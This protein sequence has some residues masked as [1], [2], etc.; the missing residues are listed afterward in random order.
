MKKFMDED[1]LLTSDAAKKLYH[2]YAENMPIV[3][4]HCHINPQEICEDRKFE[5]ITQVW[6]GGDHY[7]WR[8][9][10]SNGVDEK[11]ITGDATDR[12][13][14]QKWAETLEKLIGNPL[15]HWS[16]LE[17]KRYF[18]Y[19]GYLNGET[20]EEVWNLCN[21]KLAQDDMTVRNIIKKSNVK[22]ICTT[23]DP[24]DTLEYHEKLAKD[25]TFDV[26]VLP[27]W[28]PDKAMNLEKPE[29]L[30]YI[31]KLSEVSGIEVKSFKTL[32]EALVKRMD[33]FQERG[34][35]VSDHA[36]EYV[37]YAP[38]S[39][40]EIEA[41]YSKRLAGGE[42]T[43]EEELK[44]K[45]A[46]ILAVGK[47]YNKRDWVMQLHYGCKRDN[48]VV[49]YKQLGPDTGYDCIN[50]Y[51]PS[52]EMADMLNA[53]SDTDALPKTILY[54]LNP[55]DN[56]SIG[57]IIGCFQNE[58]TVGRIQQPIAFIY[59]KD[60]TTNYSDKEDN[61]DKYP[62][63][64]A[65]E[66]MVERD[67][68]GLYTK[69][70]D[71]EGNEVTDKN[72]DPVKHYCTKKYNAQMKK[73]FDFIN[74]NNIEFTEYSKED[75]V[76]ENY[77]ALKD[78]EKVNIKTVTYRQFAWLLQQDGNA[79]YMVGGP[80]DEATQNEIA[81]VNAKAVK[82]DVNV[83]L[84]DPYVD[85]KISED[86]WGYKNT[87]DIMKSDSINFM[88]TTLIE[89]SLTNLTTEEFE[90]GADGAS[91]TYKNDAG[92]EKT[93]P[94]I[95]SPFVFSFNKDATDEDGISAPITAY[96]EKADTL[97]AVFSAYADG[98]AK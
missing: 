14:F 50:N 23:D 49:R 78:A 18:G 27:A 6:L 39:E 28:R 35:S 12:E 90:N 83:Y 98:I 1:F 36:L 91:L 37:M 58:K 89:N 34:C 79:I 33:Y 31:K 82:N 72:G 84:W 32:I 53:L 42:I 86:D 26:K 29:Y 80:Y 20:A 8:Q 67:K 46:F 47:E 77:P 60:N 62:V 94:V 73:M 41:I 15:Y 19:E 71:E 96:S 2:D 59:N 45:T 85:G 22:L 51:A 92:E 70:Y 69:E 48:N 3:D 55:N 75:F 97:D 88:Y 9:M 25:D 65:F 13:K 52:S 11:Y 24:I 44:A 4:Y 76:R 7:K 68:D 43:K 57:T 17:L 61:A 81:D 74:D 21:E 63:M 38:A 54:S 16:H 56:E 64:Y 10:R 30:D 66:Q 40:E 87:G 93:V 5:N 95:K